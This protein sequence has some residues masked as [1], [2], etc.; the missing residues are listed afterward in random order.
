MVPSSGFVYTPT[1]KDTLKAIYNRSVRRTSDYFLRTEYSASR[2]ETDE[3][4]TVDNFELRY[5]RQVT[6]QLSLGVSG[7]YTFLDVIA[8][9][10]G[11]QANIP[12]GDLEVWGL[13]FEAEYKSDKYKLLFSHGWTEMESFDLENDS[14]T[15]QVI[16]SSPYGYGDDLAHWSNHISKLYGEYYINSKWT[17]MASIVCYWGYPGAKDYAD[18]NN[19]VLQAN[20][21]IW[22]R[23][24]GYCL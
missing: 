21:I 23:R 15:A 12:L 14:V 17:A 16:S 22:D 6:N 19:E 10:G 5:N 11:A 7:F 20:N 18:Y 9:D 24:R 8:Y 1:E 2:D 3:T 13:E 4:E